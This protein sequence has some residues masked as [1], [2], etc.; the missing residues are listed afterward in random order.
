MQSARI[1]EHIAVLL[2]A[3]SALAQSTIDPTHKF[4]WGENIGWTNWQ[5]D[6]PNAGDGVIFHE[7]Y[8]SGFIWSENAGWIS[9]GDGTPANGVN[10]S[11][12]NGSDFG[13]NLDPVSGK[14][15]G[16][17][18]GENIGWINFAGGGLACPPNPA[19]LESDCRLRGFVW[20]ENVGWINLDHETHYVAVLQTVCPT[21]CAGD[22]DGDGDTD[23]ADLGILLADFGCR[24]PPNCAGDVD[25]DCDT[26]LADLGILLADFGCMP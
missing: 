22:L 4:A 23:L 3:G 8:L 11:N 24:G 19:R 16:L 13:V 14:L 26:D 1:A 7:T 20:A 12:V 17:A 5:H 21:P 10:Y 2:A 25:R 6:A 9:V 18:W 15:S